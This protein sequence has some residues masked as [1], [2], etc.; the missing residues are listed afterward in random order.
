MP[1]EKVFL[2]YILEQLEPIGDVRYRK[3]FGGATLYCDQKVVGLICDNQLF[4]KPTEAGKSFIGKVTEAPAYKGAKNS[5]LI[6]DIDNSEWLCELVLKT[7]S[8][9]PKHKKKFK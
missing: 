1:N 6:D 7:A 8:E 5:Y 3:M 4:I 2:D 9:L